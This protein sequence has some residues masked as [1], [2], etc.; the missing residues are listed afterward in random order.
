MRNILFISFLLLTTGLTA[1]TENAAIQEGNEKY[2]KN[3]YS[4]AQKK[5]NDALKEN[6]ESEAGNF[7][8]GNALFRQKDYEGAINQY[9]KA[10]ENTNDPNIRS[11]AYHNLGNT[12]L[13]QKKY[14]ESINSYKQAL[15]NNPEDIDTKYNLAYAQKMMQQMQQQQQKN[16]DQKKEDQKKEDQKKENKSE[17]NKNEQPDKEQQKEQQPSQ[18]KQYTKEELERIMQA[19]NQDDKN[20]QEKVNKQK[21][22]SVGAE[23]EKDW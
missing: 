1:Q 7:N 8:L 12:Y 9:K 15:R 13:E 23:A 19:L 2:K 11:G 21:V 14:E 6:P 18:P 5:Y 4:G 17:Q 3:D 20:V 16:E 22:Q 10:A